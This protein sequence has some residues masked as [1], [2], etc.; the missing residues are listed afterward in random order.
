MQFLR[1]ILANG[2]VLVTE[3]EDAVK[4]ERIALR[5][6]ARAKAALKVE[7]HKNGADGAWTW[8]LAQK[9]GAAHG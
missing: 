7:S 4:A 1:T 3:I 8:S 9:A 5:T 6:L 2:P